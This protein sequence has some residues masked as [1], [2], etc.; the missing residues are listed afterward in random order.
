M[1]H[2]VVGA[3]VGALLALT[4][5]L[6]GFWVFVLV[7]VAMLIGAAVGRAVDGR[8]DLHAVVEALRGRRSSS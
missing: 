3:A 1:T 6:L 5:V 7:A 4:W 8:L 2:T